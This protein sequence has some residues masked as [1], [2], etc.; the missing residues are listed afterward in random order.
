[1]FCKRAFILSTWSVALATGQSF[2]TGRADQCAT[3]ILRRSFQLPSY[4]HDRER[5]WHFEQVGFPPSHFLLC[6]RHLLHALDILD[7]L[8]TSPFCGKS[9]RCCLMSRG[10]ASLGAI[11]IRSLGNGKR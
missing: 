9:Y 10:I 8:A 4:T 5:S 1:M 7:H 2:A 6:I 11:R 3:D